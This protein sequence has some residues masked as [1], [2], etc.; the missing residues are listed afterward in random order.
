VVKYGKMSE[1][2]NIFT[3][4][5]NSTST[6]TNYIGEYACKVDAKSR[7]MMPAGLM[8][9]F[10]AALRERFVINRSV[11]QK[12]LVLYTTDLWDETMGRLNKLNR[13]NKDNDTFIRLFNNGAV[14]VEVDTTNR[15]LLPKRLSEYAGIQSDIIMASNLNKIEI[16]S[17]ASF[18]QVV[19]DLD[20]DKFSELAEKVMGSLGNDAGTL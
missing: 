17:S 18:D 19:T 3:S 1:I 15:I 4:S 12:C 2:D 8:K 10:P 13:F 20:T 6:M 14:L 7:I 9:Q 16:W 11:F 5:N